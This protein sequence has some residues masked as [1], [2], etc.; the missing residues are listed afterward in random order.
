MTGNGPHL[1][2]RVLDEGSLDDVLPWFDDPATQ[3]SLGG[4]DW[5]QRA[6]RLMQTQP[7]S[8]DGDRVVEDRFVWIA[9][10][11]EWPVA[12]VD[13]ETYND[14]CATFAVVVAP[15]LTAANE[16]IQAAME[17]RQFG[18]AG[19][20][21]VL[22]ECL[23]GP[24][25]SFFALCD[26]TRA[27]PLMTA[28]DHKR[29]FDN[30]EGPNTGGMGAFAP[31]PLIDAAG[32]DRIMREIVDPVLAG[33]RAEGHEYR[34]F[35]YAGLMMTSEGPK[36]LEFN[37][38]LGDPETQPLMHRM[39]TD[40]LSVLV[41]G[42]TPRWKPD[43][44]VCVVL[45]AHGYPAQPRTGD[46]IQG[47]DRCPAT[48]FHAGTRRDGERLVTNGGRVLNVT[49]TGPDVRTTIDLA[50]AAVDQIHFDGA[51]YRRDIG[52]RAL[53]KLWVQ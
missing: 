22:E 42:E 47:L 52:H 26:G 51:H 36:V 40:L 19:A 21:L 16:A 2:L 30:D 18:D 10:E 44:S 33:M 6:L 23:S 45:A 29:A 41:D 11:D 8:A 12:L 24:E 13:V 32:R 28:Q 38:R 7:G 34:G 39:E 53:A 35:L 25:V 20:R 4:R 17:D 15:D 31:S 48:V 1:R 43:P 46:R 14:G 3:T 50:Y 49:A 37:A 9:Y 27:V 5:I